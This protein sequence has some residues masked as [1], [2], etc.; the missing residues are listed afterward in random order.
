MSITRKISLLTLLG[1]L[2][3]AGLAS[4]LIFLL[5]DRA[6]TIVIAEQ[7]TEH[8]D[9]ALASSIVTVTLS[10][11]GLVVAVVLLTILILGSAMRRYVRRPLTA[12]LQTMH[13]IE[14]GRL[15]ER[16]PVFADDEIGRTAEGFNRMIGTVALAESRLLELR[17]L[18][19]GSQ[20]VAFTFASRAGFP[21]VFAGGNLK[22][23]G[24]ER[25][26]LEKQARSF[27]E[28]LLPEDLPLLQNEIANL[29]KNQ[30]SRSLIEVRL[31]GTE[32]TYRWLNVQLSPKKNARG[33]VTAFHAV[34][35]D[36]TYAHEIRQAILQEKNRLEMILRSIGDAVLVLDEEQRVVNANP[37]A[38]KLTGCT[39]KEMLG[40]PYSTCVKFAD[41]QTLKPNLEFVDWVYAHGMLSNSGNH[42]VLLPKQGDPVPVKETVAPLVG[43][44]ARVI[45]AVIVFR[46]VSQ[47]REVDRM[48]T[49][50]VSVASHQLKTPLNRAKWFFELLQDGDIGTMTAEGKEL[51]TELMASN[52]RMTSLIG[53]L[54]NVSRIDH[55]QGALLDLT[56]FKIKDFLTIL[57]SE[58]TSIAEREQKTFTCVCEGVESLAITAD[59]TKLFEV[60]KNLLTNAIKYSHTGGAISL[61]ITK[62]NDDVLFIV[63]DNGIGI[64]KADQ[65]HLFERFFRAPNAIMHNAEGTGLGLAVAKQFVDAHEGTISVVSEEGKGTTFTVRI[66]TTAT[67]NSV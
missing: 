38:E 35:T 40:K 48:K 19:D 57:D 56:T 49:E 52:E 6:F 1:G 65:E 16:V 13:E 18:I 24:Y 59:R 64:P 11:A 39:L 34:G 42:S 9:A 14:G 7:R 62:E 66:P 47:E 20:T 26:T 55:G 21:I 61:R 67:A 44:M 54:L 53:D 33:L 8:A 46:D 12:L 30:A 28:L 27:G 15:N 60:I 58:F 10:V 17:Q 23:L 4:F 32:G 25:D 45:G 5:V 37:I 43:D 50:F 36:V 41:E 51:L 2:V 31:L 63:S 22:L 29:M 3:F